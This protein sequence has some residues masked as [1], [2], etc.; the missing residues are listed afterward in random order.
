MSR[1]S[2]TTSAGVSTPAAVLSVAALAVAI[3][4][5]F[6]VAD[7]RG[8]SPEPSDAPATPVVTPAPVVTPVP[9]TPAP[10]FT[11]TP[12]SPVTPAPSQ[13]VDGAEIPLDDANGNGVTLGIADPSGYLD[14]A[15][16]GD[17]GDG[18]SVRWG[19]AIVRNLD[20][21][22]IEVTWVSYPQEPFITLV[23]RAA[24]GDGILL[25]FGQEAPPAYSDAMGADRVV[26]LTFDHPVAAEHVVVEFTTA[27]D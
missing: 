25:R 12:S 15:A 10:V 23:V 21:N 19:D 1:S 27:D 9:A 13:G 24:A 8:A 5:S 3:G 26:V 17:A 22:T 4:V 18:M 20:E 16:S 7:G 11:P 14:G 2:R 6:V